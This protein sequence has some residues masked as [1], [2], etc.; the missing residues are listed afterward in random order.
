MNLLEFRTSNIQGYVLIDTK[1]QGI[2]NVIGIFWDEDEILE[3]EI[4]QDYFKTIKSELPEEGEEDRQEIIKKYQK[5]I[6]KE[7]EDFGS[8]TSYWHIKINA[9][10]EKFFRRLKEKTTMCFNKLTSSDE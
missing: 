1:I 6:Q 9:L 10:P 5:T 3:N 8:K 7:L 4:F 2:L